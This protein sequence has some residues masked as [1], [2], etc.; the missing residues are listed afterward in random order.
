[1]RNTITIT[2]L[3]GVVV[4]MIAAILVSLGIFGVFSGNEIKNGME[5]IL[6]VAVTV[7]VASAIISLV[8]HQK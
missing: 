7:V 5:K 2:R 4:V 6:G 3:I 1:M 8:N